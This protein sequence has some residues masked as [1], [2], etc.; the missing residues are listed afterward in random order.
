MAEAALDG[1]AALASLVIKIRWPRAFGFRLRLTAAL[2]W[3]AGCV[4]P[5]EIYAEVI[6]GEALDD[7][8]GRARSRSNISDDGARLYCK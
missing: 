8:V 1:K 5:V 6:D 4:S 2:I 3:L 7:E